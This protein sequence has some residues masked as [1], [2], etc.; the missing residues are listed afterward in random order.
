MIFNGSVDTEQAD[1]YACNKYMC[2]VECYYT[3]ESA[4]VDVMAE[5]FGLLYWN[6]LK[7]NILGK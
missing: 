6:V 1:N 3:G 2:P 4:S 7:T 5:F